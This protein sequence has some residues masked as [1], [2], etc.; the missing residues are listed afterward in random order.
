MI[1]VTGLLFENKTSVWSDQFFSASIVPHCHLQQREATQQLAASKGLCWAIIFT[2]EIG[3][4]WRIHRVPDINLSEAT[5]IWEL[6]GLV[7]TCDAEV[8]DV[9]ILWFSVQ[10]ITKRERER[11][12]EREQL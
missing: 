10:K 5:G 7:P 3:S 1:S 4:N 2:K 12:T 6:S 9:H 11:G 8:L